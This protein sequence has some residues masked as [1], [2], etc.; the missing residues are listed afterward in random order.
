MRILGFME[1][2]LVDWD[3]K[4]VSVI[5][6]G[7]CN[8]RCPF[9]HNYQLALDD[10]KLPETPWDDIAA[11][12][13]R[14]KDWLDGVCI[15]GGEPMMH[16][17]VFAMCRAI[18]EIGP[19]VKIDSNGYFPYPLKE[20]IESELCDFVAMDI[21]APLNEKYSAAAGRKL[22]LAPIR[23]SIRL[24]ME[25]GTGYEFRSTLVPGLIDPEDIPEIGKAVQGAEV[26]TLQH[27]NPEHAGTEAYRKKETYSRAEAEEMASS[28]KPFVKEVRLRGKFLL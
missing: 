2:S 12:L 3:G 22:D 25:S 16:P 7:G 14:K 9:C 26:F 24:L 23:R 19:K 28:L 8:F 17:E 18:K 27:Y 10:P 20:L 15:T 6:L 21:K 11:V 4:I 13:K 1:T 5:F